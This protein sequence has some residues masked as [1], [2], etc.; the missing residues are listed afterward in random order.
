[1]NVSELIQRAL[2]GDAAAWEPL[3]LAH[4]EQVFHLAYLILNDVEEAEDIAQET[5]LLAYRMLRRFDSTRPRLANAARREVGQPWPTRAL[6][7]YHGDPGVQAWYATESVVI[8]GFARGT[9]IS[10][11]DSLRNRILL[12]RAINSVVETHGTAFRDHAPGNKLQ[13]FPIQKD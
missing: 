13:S 12:L 6:S 7:L 2:K 3:V 5:S 9:D 11:D 4:Q 1:L 10:M 8:P